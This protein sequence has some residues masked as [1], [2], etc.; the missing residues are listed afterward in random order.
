M[1]F[2]KRIDDTL[3]EIHEAGPYKN[4]CIITTPHRVEIKVHD[5]SEVLNFCANSYVGLADNK[6]VIAA[7]HQV[8]DEYG[9]GLASVRFTCGTQDLHKK[10]EKGVRI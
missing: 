6:E 9:F 10:L 2:K 5:G 1:N 4:E 7:T 8:L 3:Q